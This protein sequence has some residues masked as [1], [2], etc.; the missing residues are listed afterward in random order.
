MQ[1]HVNEGRAGQ[2]APDVPVRTEAEFQCD[3]WAVR[4]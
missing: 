4:F 3:G 1:E 2:H